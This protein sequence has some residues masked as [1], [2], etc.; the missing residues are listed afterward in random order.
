MKTIK[1]IE[2]RARRLRVAESEQPY[3]TPIILASHVVNA[4]RAILDG[5][6]QEVFLVFLLDIKN[7]VLGYQEVARGAVDTCPVDTR[8][9][10]RGAVILGAS[11]IILCHCHPSGDPAPSSED[12][13][14]TRRLMEAG[15]LLGVKVHDHVIVGSDDGAYISLFEK[16]LMK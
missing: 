12:I 4:A 7:K 16:G 9:V 5:E 8:A 6:D 15:T 2:I 14:L 1:K 10:F 13:K 3:G 11:G